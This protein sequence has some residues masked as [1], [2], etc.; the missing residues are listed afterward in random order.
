MR[1]QT[2]ADRSIAELLVLD[3]KTTWLDFQKSPVLYHLNSV[4]PKYLCVLAHL[5]CTIEAG[6]S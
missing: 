5:G 3:F 6:T 1:S 4:G 2:A